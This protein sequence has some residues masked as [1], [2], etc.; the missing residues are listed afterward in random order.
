M[1]QTTQGERRWTTVLFTDMADFSGISESIGPEQVYMLMGEVIKIATDCVERQG[2]HTVDYAGDSILAV[3]GAPIALENASLHACRAAFA[4]QSELEKALPRLEK[5]Y[6]VKP[7]FR[8]GIAGGMVIFGKLGLNE[9]LDLSVIG[10]PVNQAAR[11]EALAKGG[12]ILLSDVIYQQVEGYI[13]VEDRGEHEL[14]GFTRKTNVYALTGLYDEADRFAGLKRRGLAPLVGRDYDMSLLSDWAGTDT[15]DVNILTVS[16]DAGLGKSRLIHEFQERNSERLKILVGHCQPA[17]QS[18]LF[19]PFARILETASGVP[20]GSKPQEIISAL[21]A[22]PVGD[23]ADE[24]LIPLIAGSATDADDSS[25]SAHDSYEEAL[26]LRGQLIE[27]LIALCDDT[28]VVLI[29]ED[30]HWIDQPSLSLLG[31]LIRRSQGRHIKVLISARPEFAPGWK[32]TDTVQF[33]ELGPLDDA[34]VTTLIQNRFS[35]RQLLPALVDRIVERAEGNALFAEEFARDIAN[36]DEL[37]KTDDGWD[38]PA[39][40]SEELLTGNLQHLF[41]SR[42]DRLPAEQKTIAQYAAA[43]GRTFSQSLLG[44]LFKKEDVTST[45]EACQGNGLV[46]ADPSGL[47]GDWR[48]IHALMGDAIYSSLL[49]AQ[50]PTVHE[51]I[52]E[53]LEKFSETSNTDLSRQLAHHF[54]KAANRPKAVQYLAKSASDSLK[55][56]GLE[57]ADA[58][59][60]E[61]FSFIDD[62]PEC[63]ADDLYARMVA[64]WVRVQDQR[65]NFRKLKQIVGDRLERLENSDHGAEVAMVESMHALALAHG[66]KYDEALSTAQAAID[67]ARALGD[68][69][70]EAWAKVA[71]MRVYDE[72]GENDVE[73]VI[74]LGEEIVTVANRQGDEELAMN[75]LYILNAYFRT[76]G[77]LEKS[78]EIIAR[79]EEFSETR[80]NKR[81]KAYAAWARG[82]LCLVED[83]AKRA[84][85]YAEEGLELSIPG[86]ADNRV[87]TFVWAAAMVQGADPIQALPAL[88]DMIE[89]SRDFEDLNLQHTA[90][91]S[92]SMLDFRTGK[93]R[94]GWSR[95]TDLIARLDKA[96]NIVLSR[97]GHLLRAEALLLLT[98]ALRSR[99]GG[100]SRPKLAFGDLAKAIALRI[101]GRKL[102]IS[103]FQFVCDNATLKD[104]ALFA[105]AQIGLGLLELAGKNKKAAAEYFE[106]GRKIAEEQRMDNMLARIKA[107]E[108][109]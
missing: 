58:L 24:T 86:S 64:E 87:N 95:L 16:A 70:R 21:R 105:R 68:P 18:A 109:G 15:K 43:I 77:N 65:G 89:S 85:E 33:H 35:E 71:Q 31:Q 11:L 63:V 13:S 90:E 42:V 12:E 55:L 4:F 7:S 39:S 1:Q 76:L 40:A 44:H 103:D 92:R 28:N 38:L 29:I 100:G 69:A 93:I 54:T 82:L 102:A 10:P 72:T 49:K 59:Y 9:K 106:R 67:K 107:A 6:G 79:L 2:G 88:E 46:E 26:E 66:R 19:S 91:M 25:D 32:V 27:V 5:R 108:T 14:K 56:Y 94:Q 8:I 37:V 20:S 62:E 23:A 34:T 98:G 81:A 57:D 30:A 61:A 75:G 47:D 80:N 45:I 97:H 78:R 52:G 22:G 101:T 99:G 50:I 83:N 51:E 53:A 73:K 74:A 104:G 60:E 41:M 48:F 96:G 36:S 17:T 3:F 84:L